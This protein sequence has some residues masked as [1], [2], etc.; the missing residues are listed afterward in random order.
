VQITEGKLLRIFVDES[1]RCQGKPLHEAIVAKA[2]ELGLAGATVWR[3]VAGF[4]ATHR[5]HTAKILRLSDDLP[6]VIE[7]VDSAGNIEAALP[8]I[9]ALIQASGNGGLITLEK[10]EM[11]VY[12][13]AKA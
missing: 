12:A 5:I 1:D 2:Y 3:G 9:D 10:V 7:I 6:V 11:I 13:N 4:G 8:Q